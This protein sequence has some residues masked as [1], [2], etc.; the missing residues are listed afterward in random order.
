MVDPEVNDT[1]N[2]ETQD[3]QTLSAE[4]LTEE[5]AS[6]ETTSAEEQEKIDS[7]YEEAQTTNR[8]TVQ[9]LKSN[10]VVGGVHHPI[11]VLAVPG[12]VSGMHFEAYK[13]LETILS[14]AVDHDKVMKL[15]DPVITKALPAL[16]KGISASMVMSV[17]QLFKGIQTGGKM[18]HGK[19]EVQGT[20]HLSDLLRKEIAGKKIHTAVLM[21]F[22]RE[23]FMEIVSNYPDLGDLFMSVIGFGEEAVQKTGGS[24]PSNSF[25]K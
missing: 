2:E 15:I 13:Q 11:K 3:E 20:N 10:I 8:V 17:L 19:V 9:V 5:S 25:F 18:Y 14:A 6:S 16:K 24:K 22:I 1:Q 21:K 4:T 12:A 7:A 23:N